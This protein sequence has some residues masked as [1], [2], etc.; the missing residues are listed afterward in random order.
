M[1][2]TWL[3]NRRV[4][5]NGWSGDVGRGH[6]DDGIDVRFYCEPACNIDNL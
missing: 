5:R 1:R 4:A 6:D 2:I 3:C